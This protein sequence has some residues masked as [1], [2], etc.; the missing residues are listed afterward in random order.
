LTV[1]DARSLHE[2]YGHDE[3]LEQLM[4]AAEYLRDL[5][6]S[7]RDACASH[8]HDAL[9][10]T[11][12]EQAFGEKLV[13]MS[14]RMDA[15]GAPRP[16]DDRGATTEGSDSEGSVGQAETERL[17]SETLKTPK[18]A[19]E[20]RQVERLARKL[21]DAYVATAVSRGRV[22]GRLLENVNVLACDLEKA[23]HVRLERHAA[24]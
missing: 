4:T 5:T 15:L 22:Y 20:V 7:A 17:D 24:P 3:E 14:R 1:R 6:K 19:R 2:L 16:A 11:K 12:H 18:S 23:H 10:A 21:G 9:V 13:A 8:F